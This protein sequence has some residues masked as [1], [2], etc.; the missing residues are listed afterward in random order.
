M[1][2]H[3]QISFLPRVAEDGHLQRADKASSKGFTIFP[4]WRQPQLIV[5]STENRSRN[6]FARSSNGFSTLSAIPPRDRP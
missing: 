6:C 5:L 3:F 2:L 1:S 4:C